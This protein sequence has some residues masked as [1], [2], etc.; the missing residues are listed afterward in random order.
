MA[1]AV[2]NLKALGLEVVHVKEPFE[3]ELRGSFRRHPG[4]VRIAGTVN[5]KLISFHGEDLA[6][7]LRAVEAW[8]ADLAARKGPDA[9][10][11]APAVDP[12]VVEA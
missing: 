11:P 7:A 10:E 3:E 12:D 4:E 6:G 5:N 8:Q 1:L 9:P 2:K